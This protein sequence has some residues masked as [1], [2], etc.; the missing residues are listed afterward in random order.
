MNSTNFFIIFLT[1]LTTGGLTCLALQGGLLASLLTTSKNPK[2]TTIIFLLSK[3]ISHTILGAV[4]GFLGSSL[5]ISST[6][7]GSLQIVLG[8]YLI[9]VALSLLQVHPIFRYFVFTPPKKLAKFVHHQRFDL[10][11]LSPIILG[12]LTIFLPCATTQAMELLAL[13]T[14]NPATSAAIMFF[15]TLGTTPTFFLLSFVFTGAS[16][17]FKTV[18]NQ[19]AATLIIILGIISINNG[20]S[21]MGSLYTIQNFYAVATNPNAIVNTKTSSLTDGYQTI[22][23]NVTSSGYSPRQISLTK[24]IPVKLK[25]ITNNTYSCARAFTI[26]ALNIQRIL[27]STGETII[28]F[29]PTQTGKIPFSCSMGMYT[30]IFNIQ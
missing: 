14:A 8:I 29:T 21:V 22:T 28:E 17:R 12:T 5:T 27:P 11:Y 25:L 15:F 24:N 16:H 23:V 18:F 19:V 3:I 13:G 4:L 10:Q 26:P 7:K 1:G 9:G 2:T 20:L 30:G 6:F